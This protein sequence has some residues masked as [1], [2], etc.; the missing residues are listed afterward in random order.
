M[1]GHPVRA[2]LVS[3][4]ARAATSAAFLL[5]LLALSACREDSGGGAGPGGI[6]LLPS[7]EGAGGCSGPDQ[8]FAP[9][10][11]P[12]PVPLSVLS[13]SLVSQLTADATAETLFATGAGGQVV[14]IDVSGAP[15]ETE[16]VAPGTVAT[17]LASVGIGTAPQLSGIAVLDASTLLVVDLTSNTVMAVDRTTPDTVGFFAGQPSEVAGFA[18]GFADSVAT[19]LPPARFSFDRPGEIR[20]TGSVDGRIYLSDPGNHA[21]RQIANGFVSTLGGTGAAFYNDGSIS[22]AGFDT[23]TGLTVRCTGTLLVTELGGASSLGGHRLRQIFP[24]QMGFFGSTGTVETLAGDG[25]PA[26]I[27]GEGTLAQ[28]NGPRAPL[29]TSEDDVYWLD[30]GSGI[31]RR[32]TGPLDTVDCPLWADCNAAV[33]GGGSFTPGGVLS[34]TQ[35]PAGVLFVLDATAGALY[36]VTP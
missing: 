31:L 27:E 1:R 30:S 12:S 5:G 35:T 32:M 34:L 10:Q 17:L 22:Q 2:T 28:L 9:P 24:G 21:V 33:A 36:R 6:P 3:M 29:A 11:A 7:A 19:G 15:A 20:P 16:L 13:I 14:S 4:I 23:P 8:S 18:D 25:T 26:T